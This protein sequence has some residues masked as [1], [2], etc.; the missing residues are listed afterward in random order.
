[1][2]KC[3]LNPDEQKECSCVVKKETKLHCDITDEQISKLKK[4]PLKRKKQKIVLPPIKRFIEPYGF[5]NNF[6]ESLIVYKDKPYQTAEHLFQSFKT[7]NK[8]ERE[9]IQLS[10]T[11]YHAKSIGRTVKLRKDWLKVRYKM[12]EMAVKLK[13]A[14]HMILSQALLDTG[15]RALIEGNRWHD[16]Y[17]GDC[18]CPKCK[19]IEGENQLGKILMQ[20]REGTLKNVSNKTIRNNNN[21]KKK[22][23]TTTNSRS[24]SNRQTTKT[25]I[26]KI[27]KKGITK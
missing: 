17:W 13:F 26:T 18:Y 1:M 20:I 10:Q 25:S 21:I 19:K 24:K 8:S 15:E 16:N 11:P 2:K 27:L 7:K 12:M 23:E 6:Y 9:R 3:K 14:Q 22:K 5:L 4:C